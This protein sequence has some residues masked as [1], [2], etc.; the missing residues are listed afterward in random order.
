MALLDVVVVAPDRAVWAGEARSVVVPGFLGD[1]GF[2][3]G[4]VPF[5]GTLRPGKV[6]IEPIDGEFAPMAVTGGFI[7]V[8]D[9]RVTVAV[10]F[11]GEAAAETAETAGEEQTA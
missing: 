10:E 6:R 5:L 3:P 7:A 11:S 1:I 4:H 9:D 8:D 2:L